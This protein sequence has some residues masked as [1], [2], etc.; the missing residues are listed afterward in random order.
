MPRDAVLEENE[1]LKKTLADVRGTLA[2]RDKKARLLRD[3]AATLRREAELACE[4]RKRD[5]EQ[6]VSWL[7]RMQGRENELLQLRQRA[8]QLRKAAG[9]DDASNSR[10]SVSVASETVS[11]PPP[12]L[13]SEDYRTL[14]RL[15][16]QADG[17]KSLYDSVAVL[18]PLRDVLEADEFAVLSGLVDAH[19]RRCFATEDAEHRASQTPYDLLLDFWSKVCVLAEAAS[20]NA[21]DTLL[22]AFG[23]FLNDQ[24][25]LLWNLSGAGAATPDT[26]LPPAKS[27]SPV[28]FAGTLASPE[29]VKQADALQSTLPSSSGSPTPRHTA[30]FAGAAAGSPGSPSAQVPHGEAAQRTHTETAGRNGSDRPRPQFSPR[31]VSRERQDYQVSAAKSEMRELNNALDRIE[32]RSRSRSPPRTTIHETP[33]NPLHAT[34]GTALRKRATS[35]SEATPQTV[36]PPYQTD[37]RTQTTSEDTGDEVHRAKAEALQ[38]ELSR[39]LAAASAIQRSLSDSL[40]TKDTRISELSEALAATSLTLSNRISPAE[41]DTADTQ[42][43]SSEQLT[44]LEAEKAALIA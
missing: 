5:G 34:E 10:C 40:L 14:L 13:P 23:V 12:S 15:D 25:D 38:E 7:Q 43:S 2:R 35:L 29:S 41:Q 28:A 31:S 32:S 19:Y 18:N 11:Q 22:R 33:T 26:L 42:K 3:E 6:E 8:L 21:S 16:A 37:K 17:V 24:A 20:P 44:A 1:L 27:L 9:I 30:Q 39:T 4:M 36:P